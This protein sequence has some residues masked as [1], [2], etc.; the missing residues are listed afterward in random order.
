M[1]SDYA[2]AT[3]KRCTPHKAKAF[4]SGVRAGTQHEDILLK[5][6]QEYRRV[7]VISQKVLIRL[8]VNSL[9]AGVG[10]RSIRR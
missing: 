4:G 3:Q 6:L 9:P 8:L 5:D 2:N 7:E 1:Y 10:F